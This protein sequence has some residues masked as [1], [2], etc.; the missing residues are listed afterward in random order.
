MRI[1]SVTDSIFP[2]LIQEP[3]NILNPNTLLKRPTKEYSAEY[4]EDSSTQIPVR[5]A[6]NNALNTQIKANQSVGNNITNGLALNRTVQSYLSNT[7]SDMEDIYSLAQAASDSTTSAS[8]RS[9]LNK[10]VQDALA[11]IDKIY[12][13]ASFGSEYIMRGGNITLAAGADGQQTTIVFGNASRAALGISSIDL[14]TQDGAE[15]AVTAL[16]AAMADIKNQQTR[17]K[18]DENNLQ[19]YYAA[20]SSGLKS[21]ESLLDSDY[22][23]KLTQTSLE[24][25]L[26]VIRN[27]FDYAINIQSYTLTASSMNTVF[28]SLAKISANIKSQQAEAARNK[29]ASTSAASP[30]ED[31]ETASK[32][33]NVQSG[34]IQDNT[35]LQTEQQPLL[36]GLTKQAEAKVSVF[37][38]SS[39]S[40]LYELLRK[41]DDAV[42][43]SAAVASAAESTQQAS[44]TG[45]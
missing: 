3:D 15:E 18:D 35:A 39:A 1:K 28:D 42:I 44:T 30:P 7:L 34:L 16:D 37:A 31:N 5:I 19:G 38:N 27:K 12:E 13:D 25:S 4:L 40:S 43:A 32:A 6:V 2:T 36:Y 29:E 26:A 21:K 17:A 9:D 33:L 41:Q 45:K 8:A 22:S 14:S 24:N 20:G 23:R 10:T 11:Q